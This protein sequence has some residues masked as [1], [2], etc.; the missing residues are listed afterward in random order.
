MAVTLRVDTRSKASLRFIEFVR[1]LPFVKVEEPE[2]KPNAETI[3]AIEDVEQGRT[4]KVKNS[5][6]LFKNL[7][8]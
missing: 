6:E 2:K 3:K 5:K 4:I 8:I 1:T 7:G